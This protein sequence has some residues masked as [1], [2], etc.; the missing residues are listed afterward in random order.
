[1][2]AGE[3]ITDLAVE[4]DVNRKTIRRRLDALEL[5]GAER[6][7]RTAARRAEERR[8]KRLLGSDYRNP[9]RA[10]EHRRDPP[11][12]S[13][14]EPEM[15]GVLSRRPYTDWTRGMLYQLSYRPALASV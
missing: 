15:S 12:P 6:A 1:V 3:R 11:P 2:R 7:R 4:Y 5:A 13:D 10:P 8:M 14:K 9:D